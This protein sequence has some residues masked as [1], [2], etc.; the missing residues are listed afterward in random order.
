MN[1]RNRSGRQ[2]CGE[3]RICRRIA[4]PCLRCAMASGDLKPSPLPSV[5]RDECSGG[6]DLG[7]RCV[8]RDREL[9]DLAV[10]LPRRGPVAHEPAARPAPERARNRF[11]STCCTASNSFSAS[12]G[13]SAASNISASCSRA[14][15]S[16][17]GVR[18]CFSVPASISAALRISS[19]ASSRLPSAYAIQAVRGHVLD[20]DLLQQAVGPN[21]AL[22]IGSP[23]RSDAIMWRQRPTTDGSMKPAGRPRTRS[24]TPQR[25]LRKQPASRTRPRLTRRGPDRFLCRRNFVRLVRRPTVYFQSCACFSAARCSL[26]S[27]QY[28]WE[29]ATLVAFFPKPS[30]APGS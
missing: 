4:D 29:L 11:G 17:P 21:P 6:L 24:L 15:A 27:G 25:P 9:D 3:S 2:Y 5:R 23:F 14:G 10:V 13:R 18:G 22:Q 26:T 8:G 19:S 16:G 12:A 28:F 30:A 7:P 1:E 20:G